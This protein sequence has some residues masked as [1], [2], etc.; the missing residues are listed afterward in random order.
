MQNATG[1]CLRWVLSLGFDYTLAFQVSKVTVTARFFLHLAQW[2]FLLSIQR[3]PIEA[4]RPSCWC[5]T[6]DP[7]G[8]FG[9]PVP[10]ELLPLFTKS[11]VPSQWH[12]EMHGHSTIKKFEL[13]PRHAKSLLQREH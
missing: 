10:I 6:R 11:H 13:W 8:I 12:K 9:R 7:K 4:R 2:S 5:P 1:R 3:V